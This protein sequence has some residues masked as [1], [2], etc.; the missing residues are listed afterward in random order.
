MNRNKKREKRDK[1]RKENSKWPDKLIEIP[2]ELWPDKAEG[3]LKMFRSKSFF[4]QVYQEQEGLRLSI[5]RTTVDSALKWQQD[6]S[7]EE[8]QDMKRQAGYGGHLAVEVYPADSNV[9]NVA[10]MRHLWIVKGLSVGWKR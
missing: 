9:V 5:N 1:L 6:I 7:W 8:L 10:N 2:M 4:L 3:R